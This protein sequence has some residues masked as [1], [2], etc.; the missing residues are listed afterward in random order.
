VGDSVGD[1]GSFLTGG[2]G[3][4][5]VEAPSGELDRRISSSD[6]VLNRLATRGWMP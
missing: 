3:E 4:G 1:V 6:S 5:G 2:L